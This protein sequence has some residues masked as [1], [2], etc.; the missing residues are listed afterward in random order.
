VITVQNR[1]ELKIIAEILSLC[2]HPE[3]KTRIIYGANLSWETSEKY[4]HQLL[5]LGLLEVHHSPIKYVTTRKGF[6]FLEKWKE[7]EEFL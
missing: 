7:L 2:K 5:S 4:L 1:S 6:G 3:R